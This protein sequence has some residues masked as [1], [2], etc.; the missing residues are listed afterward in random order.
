MMVQ[1]FKLDNATTYNQQSIKK[2]IITRQA[3]IDHFHHIKFINPYIQIDK[4]N[5]AFKIDIEIF[6]YDNLSSFLLLEDVQS[7]TKGLC[8]S[9]KPH[10]FNL[11]GQ[12]QEIF[13]Q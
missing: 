8:N 2:S 11:S 13:N 10:Y 6:T 9:I 4:N 1:Y 12:N 7:I 5:K 3:L